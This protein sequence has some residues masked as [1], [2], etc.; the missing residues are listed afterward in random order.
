MDISPAGIAADDRLDRFVDPVARLVDK[1]LSRDDV[2]RLFQG[3]WL[4]HP[5]HPALTDLP[6]GFWTSAFALD[7]GGNRCRRA[8]DAMVAAGLV[9]VVPTAATGLADWHERDRRER[10]IGVVHAAGNLVATGLYALSLGH[11][12][13]GNRVRGVALGV[14]GATAA[15]AAA[16]LGGHLAFAATPDDATDEAAGEQSSER[17]EDRP[18]LDVDPGTATSRAVGAMSRPA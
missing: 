9:S 12:L 5:V 16:Y 2:R 6:I 15:T 17:P 4:G 11:R 10:R 14:A 1:V 7:F 3:D 18:L 13:R 8:A